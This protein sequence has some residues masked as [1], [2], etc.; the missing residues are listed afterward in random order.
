MRVF[1][2]DNKKTTATK[3]G[4]KGVC[5]TDTVLSEY[6]KRVTNLQLNKRIL[7]FVHRLYS[8]ENTFQFNTLISLY[9]ISVI[10][11]K[12]LQSRNIFTICT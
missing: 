7:Q 2:V 12:L 11:I 5:Q 1:S 6:K 3:S 9:T 10:S 4:T 8:V